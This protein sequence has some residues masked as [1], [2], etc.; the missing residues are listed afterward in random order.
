MPGKL[1]PRGENSE[2]S[3]QW[4]TQAAVLSDEPS[5]PEEQGTHT[6]HNNGV[7]LP[8]P[9]T[10]RHNSMQTTRVPRKDTE[11]EMK[12]PIE[13]Q[14]PIL[15]SVPESIVLFTP[16]GVHTPFWNLWTYPYNSHGLIKNTSFKYK[17]ESFAGR[18]LTVSGIQRLPA[19]EGH[20]RASGHGAV[21]LSR[22]GG[23][24]TAAG[25]RA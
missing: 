13:R 1:L 16:G 8:L 3:V 6:P 12:S 22:M 9:I 23:C 10:C 5:R 18:A 2:A 25:L 20:R 19:P 24:W 14:V 21:M 11:D 15:I 4:R 17:Y 7:S